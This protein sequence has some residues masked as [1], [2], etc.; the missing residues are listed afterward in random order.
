M[1]YK[2]RDQ[3]EI[4]ESSYSRMYAE[5]IISRKKGKIEEELEELKSK[6]A[7]KRKYSW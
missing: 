7:S 6:K 4:R 1:K 3:G 5:E 2:I